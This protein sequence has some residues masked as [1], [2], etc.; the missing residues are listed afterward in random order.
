MPTAPSSSGTP[1][2][3]ASRTR[4]GS[5]PWKAQRLL[6]NYMV[7]LIDEKCANPGNDV[8]SDVAVRVRN[9][10][11]VQRRR[12]VDGMLLLVGGHETTANMMRWAP[13]RC[14]STLTSWRSS[15]RPTTQQ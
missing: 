14:S 7:Q 5:G 12:R 3:S 15:G 4:L 13:S 11:L 10:E 2:N 1:S 9:G 6:V 8:M